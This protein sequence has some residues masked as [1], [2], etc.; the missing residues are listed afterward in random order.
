MTPRTDVLIIG[1]GYLGLRAAR[2]WVGAG[3]RVAALTRGRAEQLRQEQIEPIVGDVLDRASLK[4]VPQAD[5]L[6]YAVGLDRTSGQTMQAVYVDGL[7]NVLEELA[8]RGTVMPKI[9]YVSSTSVYGQ[10]DG[11]WVT[12]HSPTQPKESSGQVVLAAEHT[13]REHAPEA[14]ILRFSG[15]YGPNRLLRK[16]SLL[17]GEPIPGKP[18]RFLNLIQVDDGAQ[19][20]LCAEQHAAPGSLYLIADGQP[21]TRQDYFSRLA[22]LIG[23]PAIQF[24]PEQASRGD[25]HRRVISTS[26][27]QELQWQP[28]HPNYTFGLRASVGDVA[29]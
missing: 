4:L 3:K 10:T 13:L 18:D 27:Q 11:E 7:R 24:A 17:R 1:C 21:C 29:T 26:A 9:L 15:I 2:F 12:E 25:G 28:R 5:T 16:E 6:L 23:A 8:S 22:E 14:V 19:A 20:I